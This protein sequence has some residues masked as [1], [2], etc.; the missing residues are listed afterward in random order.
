MISFLLISTITFFSSFAQRP[1][2]AIVNQYVADFRND[3][4]VRDTNRQDY[5]PLLANVVRL[6]FHACVGDGGCDGCI[7]MNQA[8]NAGL[9]LSVDYLEAKTAAWVAAGLSKA[10][11]YALAHMV[12]ANMALGNAGWDSD[13]SDFE[14]GRTDCAVNSEDEFPDAHASPFQFFEDNFGFTPR[15]TTVIFGAHTLGRALPGNSGFVNFWSDNALDLGNGFYEAIERNPWRQIN[16]GNGLFQWDQNRRGNPN[17]M[18]LNADMF[19]VRDL[20]PNGNGQETRCQGN[21]NQCNDADTLEIVELFT[22]NAGEA[23]FQQEFKEVYTRMIRSAGQGFE[24]DLALICDVFDC[25]SEAPTVPT[26]TTSAQTSTTTQ[27]VSSTTTSTTD[28]SSDDDNGRPGRDNNDGSDDNNATESPSEGAAGVSAESEGSNDASIATAIGGAIAGAVF[29]ALLATCW[30]FAPIFRKEASDRCN[31][32]WRSK[33]DPESQ[34][35][36]STMKKGKLSYPAPSAPPVVGAGNGERRPSYWR[37]FQANSTVETLPTAPSVSCRAAMFESKSNA[38]VPPPPKK[39]ITWHYADDN[40][41]DQGPVSDASFKAKI[42]FA[43]KEQTYVWNGESVNDWT[44]AKDVPELKILFE[45][46]VDRRFPKVR[47]RPFAKRAAFV[48]KR[49]PNQNSVSDLVA[50]FNS[51]V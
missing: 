50:R 28:D 45:K 33:N 39:T 46:K 49:Q 12:A 44:F 17:L 2:P 26:A 3:F 43:V 9:E 31:E 41:N 14:I 42:G 13:L 47:P 23:V 18:A 16:V 32:C 38:P 48:S 24:Q 36:T 35:N 10:D 1:L 21:F 19:L 22:T 5:R 20:V 51:K 27:A 6:A 4:D 34:T 8:D 37:N 29:L 25:N 30:Y 7:N 15:D 11:L 40:G